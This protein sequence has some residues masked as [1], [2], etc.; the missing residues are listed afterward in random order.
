[1]NKT[2]IVINEIDYLT[3]PAMVKRGFNPCG[4]MTEALADF[5]SAGRYR[6]I[7][8]EQL[9]LEDFCEILTC[10]LFDVYGNYCARQIIENGINFEMHTI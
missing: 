8:E 4:Y 7:S 5:F 2:M 1:M 6:H 3:S 10:W 9:R